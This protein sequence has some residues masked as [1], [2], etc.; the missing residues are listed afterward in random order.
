MGEDVM[1]TQPSKIEGTMLTTSAVAQPSDTRQFPTPDVHE[2]GDRSGPL[3]L[4]VDDSS[5][6]TSLY[7]EHLLGSGFRV[8][9][10]EDGY[11]GLVAA[12]AE[13]PDLVVMDLEMPRMDGCVTARLLKGDER[14]SAIPILAL[15]G[16][17][18][19]P[20][21]MRAILAGCGGFIPKP[22]S[23]EELEGIIRSTLEK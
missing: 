22:C 23:A 21:V 8:L 9:T 10:A 3:I 4:L 13:H 7:R 1:R 19:A 18:G 12:R 16:M 20:S 15:S 6:D 5:D 11:E 2:S 14:T 17:H